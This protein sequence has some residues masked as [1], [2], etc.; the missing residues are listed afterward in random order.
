MVLAA[1]PWVIDDVEKY[2]DM[3]TN[4]TNSRFGYSGHNDKTDAF[5]HCYFSALLSA[6][7]G[8]STARNF[9]E[10]HELWDG[11]PVNEFDMDMH[12]NY[13]GLK[14]GVF[15]GDNYTLSNKCMEALNGN[16]LKVMKK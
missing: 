16:K 15:G 13:I 1:N 11:N 7:I 14:I 5:R 9:V 4:E 6:N 10:A 8:Y 12:N 3:A 2:A